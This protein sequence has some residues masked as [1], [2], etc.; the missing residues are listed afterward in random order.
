MAKKPCGQE[1]LVDG[2]SSG[3]IETY[4]PAWE[5]QELEFDAEAYTLME[6]IDL[7]WPAQS[8]D[9]SDSRIFLGTVPDM[10]SSRASLDLVRIDIKHT[11]FKHLHYKKSRIDRC[12][13]RLR[14]GKHVFALS[15]SHLTKYDMD[16]NAVAEVEGRYGFALCVTETYVFAGSMDGFVECYD[17]NLDQIL[18]FRA[19]EQSI[20]SIAFEDGVIFTGSVDH[21]VR[22]FKMDGSLVE[23]LAN[24]SEVN[25]LDVRNGK[26][27]FGDEDG[28]L[29]IYSVDTK[30]RETIEWHASPISLVRWR[31]SDIFASG[32]DEQVCLWDVTLEADQECGF[33]QYLLF[34]HQGQRLYKDCCFEGNR[35]I[36]T[37]EDGLCVF[38]PISFASEQVCFGKC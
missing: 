23:E 18:R 32:S 11:D 15:D 9:I 31:D 28:L 26:L 34:V 2:E 13:N 20:E 37:A 14:V 19:H 35:V 8:I 16:L 33:S 12:I 3:D 29:H 1:E 21:T 4:R 27:V 38:E 22:M 36:V 30:T 17:S 6:Y 25:C 10:S 5:D 24:G 7:E